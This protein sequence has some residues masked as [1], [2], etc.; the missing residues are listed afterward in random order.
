MTRALHLFGRQR[1][2][3]AQS[4]ARPRDG[5][6]VAGSHEKRQ[7]LIEDSRRLGGKA[8]SGSRDG[9]APPKLEHELRPLAFGND[10]VLERP[11]ITWARKEGHIVRR[12]RNDLPFP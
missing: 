12:P 4:A 6:R 11:L 10:C 9:V 5:S 1:R 7:E 3:L 8:A 2:A